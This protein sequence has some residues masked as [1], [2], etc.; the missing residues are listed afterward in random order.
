[1]H[2]KPLILVPRRCILGP[3]ARP[4][5]RRGFV[6]GAGASFAALGSMAQVVTS[7]SPAQARGKQ[8]F[9]GYGP[10]V[11]DPQGVL[12]LPAGF[13]YSILSREG[14]AMTEHGPVP[15]LHDGMGAFPALFA[16][17]LVRNHEVELDD[18]EEDG[19]TPVPH[20]TGR[21][22]DPEAVGGTTTLL[23]NW[24]RELVRDEVSL[25]GTSN[26]CAGGPT[27][28]GTWLTC[29]ETDEFLGK[30]HGYVFEV[31]PR[32]GG[33]PH[34]I[35][36]MGRFEHE[37]VSFD[38]RGVAYLTEDAD[39]PFGCL[40]RYIPKR[41]LRGL[42]SLH[43]GGTLSALSVLGVDTDLSIVSIPGTKFRAAWVP[44]PESNPKENDTT[45]REQAIAGG[46]T[47][48]PKCEGTWLGHDGNI[49]FV[50]SRGDGPDAEDEEDRSAA[51]HAGQIW[52]YDPVG[53]TVELV[54]VF[55]APFDQP[56]NI[57]VSPHGFA[58]ACTD[59]DDDQWLVGVNDAGGTF[60]FALNRLNEEEF[61]GATFS[62]FGET[63]FVNVQ[64]PPGLTFAVWGPW[65]RD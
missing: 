29:E 36:A 19:L 65:R 9:A 6:V 44:V 60:P 35:V 58:L 17:Y 18:V 3:D 51:Q 45:T 50:S 2:D 34:P 20:V 28:W 24:R 59:G 8:P 23:V 46:A 53:G 21:T 55:A 4:L 30:P 64:G 41:R 56:D 25:A 49:W 62:P 22:Y 52:K 13:R 12:D 42:G 40:Y 43:A 33:N 27:P 54:V 48:I 39:S 63:L 31:D 38:R 7:T 5:S 26:N 15:S 16:T 32:R 14:D 47:P 10:L 1:M 11:P 57:T 37:A 61:A